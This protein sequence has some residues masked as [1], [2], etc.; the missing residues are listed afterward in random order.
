MLAAVEFFAPHIRDI[1][2]ES[3]SE[4]LL[5]S[6]G[7]I[8]FLF[9]TAI[10]LTTPDVLHSFQTNFT[11]HFFYKQILDHFDPAVLNVL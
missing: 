11:R 5:E 2:Y 7:A 8:A 10:F 9:S 4:A 1:N 6:P 3:N